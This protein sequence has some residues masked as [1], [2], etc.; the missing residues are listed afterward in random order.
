MLTQTLQELFRRDLDK[1]KQEIEAYKS[2]DALWRTDKALPNSGGNLA[3][4]LCGNLSHFIGATLGN[5]GYVRNRDLEFSDKG[6][7]RSELV[8]KIDETIA[9]V[10]KT[11][12]SITNE[13]LAANYTLEVFK[14]KPVMTTEWMLVHLATHLSYHLGQVNYH[15]R[16][17]DAE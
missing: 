6:V 4:H 1:L 13:Q 8:K 16:M 15:R 5:S 11:L 14:D 7:P 3:L 17:L 2:D 9:A 12:A 10:D